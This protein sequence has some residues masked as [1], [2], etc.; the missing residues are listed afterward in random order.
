LRRLREGETGKECPLVSKAVNL[1]LSSKPLW[2]SLFDLQRLKDKNTFLT[3]CR[4]IYREQ[5]FSFSTDRNKKMEIRTGANE[6]WSNKNSSNVFIP[7]SCPLSYIFS[8][9][10]F[11]SLESMTFNIKLSSSFLLIEV[12]LVH[13][14]VYGAVIVVSFAWLLESFVFR[15]HDFGYILMLLLSV[16]YLDGSL[17]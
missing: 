7:S 13:W 4:N 15:L 8:S 5:L 14:K 17:F 10:T 16:F 9:F 11:S 3:T 1:R 2:N 6:Q 12:S